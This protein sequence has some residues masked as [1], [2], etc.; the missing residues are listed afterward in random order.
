MN[1]VIAAYK[2]MGI[3]GKTIDFIPYSLDYIDDILRLR[4]QIE[5]KYFLSQNYDI[6]FAQQKEWIMNYLKKEDEIGYIVKNKR[7]DIVGTFFLYELTSTSIELGRAVF[8]ADKRRGGPYAVET[9]LFATDFAF[10]KLHLRKMVAHVKEDNTG[11]LSL[12]CKFNFKITGSKVIRGA[13]YHVM[14]LQ[15]D[16]YDHHHI[17]QIVSSRIEQQIAS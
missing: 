3:Q 15:S 12:L 1:S 11:L 8:S 14:A 17:N 9:V 13:T 2:H 6:T 10:N 5:A 4:N 16:N 7:G